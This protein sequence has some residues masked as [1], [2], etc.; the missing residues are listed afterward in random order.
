[1]NTWDNMT[2]KQKNV[3]LE[4]HI[5]GKP[6]STLRDT[7]GMIAIGVPDYVNDD[8]AALVLTREL[9]SKEFL[10]GIK[11]YPEIQELAYLGVFTSTYEVTLY[12]NSGKFFAEEITVS[13]AIAK[14]AYYAFGGI[15]E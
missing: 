4:E 2:D 12:N 13:A 15:N 3:W 5:T 1:M 9:L 10:I 8:T 6:I 11:M 14:A 7:D